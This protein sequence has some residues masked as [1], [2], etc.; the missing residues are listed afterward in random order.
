[1]VVN[2][3]ASAHTSTR[4][5][6]EAIGPRVG[7][8]VDKVQWEE[9]FRYEFE[10]ALERCP[11][12][13]L[14][15]GTLERHGAHL[16]YGQDAMKA[17]GLCVAAARKHG[18][19][20][21]PPL[22]WGTHGNVFQEDF[23]RGTGWGDITQPTGSV[24]ITEGVLMAL[25]LE[26]F[27]EIEYCGFKVIVAL[28]DHYP[29]VKVTANNFA[30]EQFMVTSKVRV[31]AL[32][33]YE[34]SGE[35]EVGRDHAGKWETYLFWAMYPEL[36]DMTRLPDP[37]TGGYEFTS[38]AAHEASR[39]S[40]RRWWITLPTSSARERS[41]CWRRPAIE[42]WPMPALATA[43]NRPIP[44]ATKTAA[45]YCSGVRLWVEEQ[46]QGPWAHRNRRRFQAQ[47]EVGVHRSVQ[48]HQQPYA[49]GAEDIAGMKQGTNRCGAVLP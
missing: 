1:M 19:V 37:Q 20:V 4:R 30:A 11:I 40:G 38:P 7:I 25:A 44:T 5:R 9:M 32:A 34:V 2:S 33:E 26:M 48:Q 6:P 29:E 18:G 47:R 27:R 23:K 12:C 22:H 10:G 3:A 36:T 43:T 13:Y 41:S 49:R 24:Y 14:P 16:P 42:G 17:H 15:F 35:V 46:R 31:W 28:T 21:A 45:R 8:H 39:N